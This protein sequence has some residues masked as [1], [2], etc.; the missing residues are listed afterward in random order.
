MIASPS[1]CDACDAEDWADYGCG[2]HD[3]AGKGSR[4]WENDLTDPWVR[5][6]CPRYLLCQPII[7]QIMGDVKDYERGAMGNVLEMEAPYLAC[8]RVASSELTAWRNAMDRQMMA[9]G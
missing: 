4:E 1:E 5:R 3:L 6:T 2:F 8:L 9:H 7:G